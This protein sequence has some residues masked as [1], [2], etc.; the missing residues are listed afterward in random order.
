MTREELYASIYTHDT[1][2]CPPQEDESALLEVAVGCSWGKCTFCDFARDKFRVF[3]MAEIRQKLE[4]LG[5]LEPNKTRLFLL[6]ENAFTLSATALCSIIDM[7][8]TYMPEVTEFA[9]YARADDV[10]HKSQDELSL[11]KE[12]GV[13]EL[14]IGVESGSDSILAMVN[15]GVTPAE[16]LDATK[17]LDKAGISYSITI[18][19]GLGGKAYRN[20]HALETARLLN[21]THPKNIWCLAL[22]LWPGTSLEREAKAGQFDPLTPWELLLEER[23]LLEN[24]Q[25]KGCFFMDTTVLNTYTIEGFLP[26]GKASML[27]AI[28]GLLG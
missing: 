18:I 1:V 12:R 8:N 28:D 17:R 14:H 22:K 24:L 7:A 5:S 16:I 9:M 11:L 15:K 27:A 3:S 21:K 4:V 23:I 19:L 10:L 25:V 20:L 26:E 2:Y 13:S 6:G